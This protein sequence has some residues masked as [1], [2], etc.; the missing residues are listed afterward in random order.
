MLLSYT[1]CNWNGRN[2]ALLM[3]CCLVLGINVLLVIVI[4]RGL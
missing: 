4:A 2:C 3:F 1:S